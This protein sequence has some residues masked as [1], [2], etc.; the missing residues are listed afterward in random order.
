MGGGSRRTQPC[1]DGYGWP[2]MSRRFFGN[3]SRNLINL[4]N[5]GTSFGSAAEI[6]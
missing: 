1:L 6:C 3:Q 4:L 2:M 5:L